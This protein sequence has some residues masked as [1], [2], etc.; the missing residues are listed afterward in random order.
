M[1]RL[2]LHVHTNISFDGEYA[3]GELIQMC[4]EKWLRTVAIADHNSTGAYSSAHKRAQELRIT[5]VPAVELDC[6]IHGT[7]LHIL[8][9]GINPFNDAFDQYKKFTLEQEQKASVIRLEA[10]R[11]LGIV[12]EEERIQALAIDGV[13]T[14]EMLAE[15]ALQD[16]KND[17]QPLLI[18]YRGGGNRSDNPYGNFYWDLCSQ[19]K[20]AYAPVKFMTLA[21][22]ITMI[23]DAGGFAVLAHPGIS[24][25]KNAEL[26]QEIVTSGICGVEAYSS[27]HDVDTIQFYRA[28]GKEQNVF[29]TIGSDFHG[30]TKPAIHLGAFSVQEEEEI[31]KAFMKQFH[32]ISE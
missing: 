19:G 25:G 10:I 26:F 29:L 6:H 31:H 8:G 27:Y 24:I 5:L 3:P 22:A 9:Y 7:D 12:V 18:P 28:L 20:P 15:V 1:N 16:M 21:Q 17:K 14:G 32:K 30:K 4:Y 23:K 13:I 11:T 2:D